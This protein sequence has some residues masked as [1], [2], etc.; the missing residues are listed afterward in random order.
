MTLKIKFTLL[1]IL[2]MHEVTDNNRLSILTITFH[3]SIFQNMAI[4]TDAAHALP[5]I[6]LISP[7][8]TKLIC[9]WLYHFHF[10]TRDETL[11][12]SYHFHH[13]QKMVVHRKDVLTSQVHI[14]SSDLGESR[15]DCQVDSWFHTQC[16][17]VKDVQSS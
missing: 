14:H 12:I 6:T 10:L 17:E 3:N 2:T 16:P 9:V 13:Q 8:R 11:F 7:V 5:D 4:S 1:S 15:T